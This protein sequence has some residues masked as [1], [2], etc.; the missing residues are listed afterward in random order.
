MY[1]FKDEE[2]GSEEVKMLKNNDITV[3]NIDISDMWEE[4]IFMKC[5][6][7]KQMYELPTLELV[8]KYSEVYTIEMYFAVCPSCGKEFITFV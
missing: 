2:C 7:C 8:R 3:T 1:F 4:V 6:Y 5:P